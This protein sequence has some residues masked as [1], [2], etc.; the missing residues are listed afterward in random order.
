MWV[1]YE[2]DD[3]HERYERGIRPGV[4]PGK[5]GESSCLF[6]M[7]IRVSEVLILVVLYR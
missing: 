4:L 7:Q 5:H 3:T 2:I 1:R 6:V